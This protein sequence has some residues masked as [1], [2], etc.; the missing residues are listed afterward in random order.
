M[1]WN[2][3]W[4]LVSQLR[5]ACARNKTFLW[6]TTCLAGMTIRRDMMGVTSIVRALGLTAACYDRVL[7]FFHSP[8]LD[9]HKLTVAWR[10]LVF[11]HHPGILRVGGKPVLVGDGIKVAKAGRKMPA[12]KRLHQ[13][14]DSNTKPS[15]SSVIP[16]RP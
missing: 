8:S 11:A 4:N 5:P 3:W 15:T 9:L 12:V 13:E 7:D 10:A 6:M 2:Y 16:A 14:S 1:L